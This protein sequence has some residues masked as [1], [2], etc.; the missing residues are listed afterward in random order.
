MLFVAHI[1]L[2]L[3]PLNAFVMLKTSIFLIFSL[4]LVALPSFSGDS[5]PINATWQRCMLAAVDSFPSQ[6]GYYTGSRPNADFPKTAWLALNQAFDMGPG[7][8]R[9]Q[10]HPAMACPSFCSSAT[11]GALVQALLLWDT[12][13]AISREAWINMKPRVGIAD[14]LNPQGLSQDDGVGFWGRCNANGPALAVLV[15]ELDAGVSYTGYRGAKSARN[16]ETPDEPYLTD[17]QWRHHPV[18]SCA[19]P[20]DIMKIF[21]N[22]NDNRGRD[23]GAI[24]G[25][26]GV[27]GDDQEAGHSVV[28]LGYAPN[29]QVT[30]WSSNGPG[31]NPKAMGYG[32]GHCDRT[33]IQRV[34]I[35][36]ILRPQ[37]F[38]RV[39]LMAPTDVNQ[40]LFDLNGRK[41]ST[42]AEL[43][44][45]C[46][47]E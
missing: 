40:Y 38:N 14:S 12:Q 25:Y 41:H 16:K 44:R 3:H 5:V 34:V 39:R 15:H 29:G 18:W 11:Y 42:T 37:N 26:N 47:I 31:P 27:K 35:T 45:Q 28:F 24:V 10:F 8:A 22:R 36:R 21:W 6:G 43:K 1:L 32:I 2:T 7:D 46:G 9:P 20:G 23:C 13:G 17:D 30:Y 33:A 19:R 4:L